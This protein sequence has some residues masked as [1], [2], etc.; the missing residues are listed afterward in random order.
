MGAKATERQV[1]Q[2]L[3]TI[4]ED[5]K[6]AWYQVPHLLV[7]NINLTLLCLLSA[8][9]GYDYS[10]MNGLQALVPWQEFLDHPTGAWLG[11]IAAVQALGSTLAYAYVPWCNNRF[12]RKKTLAGGYVWIV[13][14]TVVMAASPNAT[15]FI[16]GR[17][18]TG[19]ASAH[20]S[21]SA[22]LL[23]TETAY[24]THRGIL[25]ALFNCGFYVGA[26][27]AAWVTYGTRDY[28]SSLAWRVPV[29]L[30]LAVPGIQFVGFLMASES[31]RWLV[32]K[33][34]MDEARDILVQKHAGGDSNSALVMF[35][36]DEIVESLRLE[37]EL[38]ATVKISDLWKTS[39][40][41]HRLFISVS[42]GVMAQWNGAGVVSY[43]LSLILATVGITSVTD[44]T[45]INGCLQIWNLLWAVTSAFLVDRVG[46]RKIF[47]TSTV[48]MF[49]CYVCI[50][51][52]SGAFANSG[53]PSIGIAVI[54]ML[55]IYYGFY[56]IAFTPLLVAYPAEI[57]S[58]ELRSYG[59]NITMAT[60]MLTLFLN[61]FANPIAL[62]AIAWK[63]YIVYI[64]IL[65][66]MLV[67]IYFWF[68]ETRGHTLEEMAKVFDR[69]DDTAALGVAQLEELEKDRALT[70]QDASKREVVTRVENV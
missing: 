14:G 51:G 60:T 36:F 48:G 69:G 5:E 2:S 22:P 6:R 35:E 16:L 43:Y 68:P 7:L 39:G 28:T 66:I 47:L 61:I 46:R 34:R 42:L 20:F 41:R 67:V 19:C 64:V 44:Q 57:W 31:P 24:P 30:Q 17:F 32:S 26:L 27:L 15:A 70:T 62:E 59:L 23:I 21:G 56:D 12:G 54:P 33:G 55:F 29:I 45:L 50:T 65:I 13:V 9:N 4:L 10:L 11:F 18:L 53:T 38:S 1:G 40:N 3:A 63:Y 58:Y 49:A 37:R 25:T 8:A 52:L